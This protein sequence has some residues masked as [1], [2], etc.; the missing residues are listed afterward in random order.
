MSSL[1]K[2]KNIYYLS[3]YHNGKRITKRLKSSEYRVVKSLK[4]WMEALL[5]RNLQES[6]KRN[7]E[8][9][10]SQLLNHF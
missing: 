7:T 1:H 6:K 4:P 9:S 5:Y 8:L 3:L 2:N 10:L